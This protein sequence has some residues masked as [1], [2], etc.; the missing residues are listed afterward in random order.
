MAIGAQALLALVPVMIVLA[1]FLPEA[2]TQAGVDHFQSVTGLG[3]QGG[4][5]I[6]Q[7][8]ES[9]TSSP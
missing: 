3:A 1:A 5:A 4:A 6:E 8:V 2:V 7:A 9:A